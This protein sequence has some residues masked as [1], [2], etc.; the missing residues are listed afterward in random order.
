[1]HARRL[2][3]LEPIVQQLN[4]QVFLNQLKDVSL[5]AGQAAQAL[6]ELRIAPLEQ[7][8]GHPIDDIVTV[9]KEVKVL[10]A[11]HEVRHLTSSKA[12][13]VRKV[14][15]A[16]TQACQMFSRFISY[17]KDDR[18]TTAPPSHNDLVNKPDKGGV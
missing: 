5:Q 2:Q 14:N 16:I 3:I 8:L 6:A 11:C 9:E 12:A 18:I 1:M 17:F 15:Q 13:D 4:S 10:T 7:A